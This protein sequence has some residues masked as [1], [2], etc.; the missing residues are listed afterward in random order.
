[1]IQMQMILDLCEAGGLDPNDVS[2]IE[3]APGNVVF[4]VW[5][6]LPKEDGEDIGKHFAVNDHPVQYEVIVPIEE[7]HVHEPGVEHDHEH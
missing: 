3:I 2:R 6:R 1:M 4:T 7:Q 5:V